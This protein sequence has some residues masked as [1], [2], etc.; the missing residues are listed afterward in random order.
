MYLTRVF[1]MLK[2]VSTGWIKIKHL[3]TK[4]VVSQKCMNTFYQILLV[5]STYNYPRVCCF[6]LCLL[7]E[8]QNY[9]NFTN[10]WEIAVFVLGHFVFTHHVFGDGGLWLLWLIFMAVMALC[11]CAAARVLTV[12]CLRLISCSF[13]YWQDSICRY[14]QSVS[15]T[16]LDTVH[17]CGRECEW[18]V[19]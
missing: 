12:I 10:F 4:T 19:S 8:R 6:M 13:M 15:D 7:D 18:V 14:Y 5:C 9:R 2:K 3:N 11:P 16:D 17:V 1:A